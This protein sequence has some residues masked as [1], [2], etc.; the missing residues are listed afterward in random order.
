[1]LDIYDGNVK[2]QPQLTQQH[3]LGSQWKAMG[4]QY[5]CQNQ[6]TFDGGIRAVQL[7]N[8][9]KVKNIQTHHRKFY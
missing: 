3:V 6:V 2:P 9:E 8:C 5:T 7:Q 1:M 4:Y